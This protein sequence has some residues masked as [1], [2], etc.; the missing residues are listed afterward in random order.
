M[1]FTAINL[2]LKKLGM[3]IYD[4]VLLLND[5]FF[6]SSSFN[7]QSILEIADNSIYDIC[8]LV[9][10]YQFNYHVQ[11]FFVVLKKEALVSVWFGE[12]WRNVTILDKKT[13]IIFKYEIGMSQSAMS[14]SLLVG[15]CYQW[16]SKSYLQAL[17]NSYKKKN[18]KLMA[19]SF[20]VS[21]I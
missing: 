8:G 16:S 7:I 3:Y 12:F 13:D 19:L 15:S 2:G 6:I 18:W 10:S 9:D 1:T 4:Q 21:S 14:H 17:F 5:S 11:S 20:L